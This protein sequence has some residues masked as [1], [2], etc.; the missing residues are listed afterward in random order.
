MQLES[1]A[2]GNCA[3]DTTGCHLCGN[4]GIESPE[5]CDGTDL[6]GQSCRSLG[7]DDGIL[8]CLPGCGGFDVSGCF[9]DP[10]SEPRFTGKEL[11]EG[12]DLYYF[13]ARYLDAGVGRFT[14]PDP[15]PWALENPQTFNRYSYALN[16]P[17]RFVDPD[18]R[19]V[20]DLLDYYFWQQ[21]SQAWD[22]AFQAFLKDPS[23]A[24]GGAAAAAFGEN[25]LDTVALLPA[26][27]SVGAIRRAVEWLT[28][29]GRGKL[30]RRASVLG[31]AG[32]TRG[33]RAGDPITNLTAHGE[34]PA[35]STVRARFWKNEAFNNSSTYSAENLARMQRGLAPQRVNPLT[36]AVESMELHHRPPRREGGLFDVTPVWPSEHAAI[37]PFRHVGN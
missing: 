26:V 12:L 22:Q 30:L 16:G 37:D 33:W 25:S 35:W 36:G 29:A 3:F 20:W 9:N 19:V 2:T 23:T 1:N 27:P 10:A 18:G 13:G 7:Y 24:T 5:V 6:G 17:Y 32:P 15:G 34:V 4:D 8:D 11:E 21:S 31:A 14:T 28:N